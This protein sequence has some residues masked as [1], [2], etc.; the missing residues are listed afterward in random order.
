VIL[1]SVFVVAV[2]VVVP[3][4]AGAT[5]YTILTSSMAPRHP[6]GT[7]VVVRPRPMED[8]GVGTI[9][10]Y[11]LRSGEPAVVTHRVV[12]VAAR[13]NGERSFVTRGDANVTDDARPVAEAQVRGALWYAVP[14]VGWVSQFLDGRQRDLAIHFVAGALGVYAVWMVAGA[15]RD[16]RRERKGEFA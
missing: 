16:R 14:Y 6:P 12:G 11:Q 7:L 10:T 1:T 15:L 8:I 3:R 4:I 13:G 9:I 2:A 5:P